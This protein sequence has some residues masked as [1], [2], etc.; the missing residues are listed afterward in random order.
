VTQLTVRR[1]DLVQDGRIVCPS[2]AAM[3][4][5]ILAAARMTGA[6]R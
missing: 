3:L 4:P 6:A 5:L 1:G 2:G